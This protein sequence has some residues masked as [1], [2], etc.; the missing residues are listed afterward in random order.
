MN[1]LFF[2]KIMKIE[3][4]FIILSNQFKMNIKLVLLLLIFSTVTVH[5]NLSAQD[6]TLPESEYSHLKTFKQKTNQ[7]SSKVRHF[8]LLLG[9]HRTSFLNPTF[10]QNIGNIYNHKF[11]MNLTTRI[12]YF[13]LIFDVTAFTE[14]IGTSLNGVEGSLSYAFT[15]LPK[16]SYITW[17]PYFGAGYQYSFLNG[18]LNTSSPLI[19]GGMM[20][21]LGEK[22]EFILSGEFK[23]SLPLSNERTFTQ[24]SINMGF[25]GETLKK[26]GKITGVTTCIGASILGILILASLE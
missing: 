3:S 18:S 7:Y 24:Y 23:Q 26:I 2:N 21:N 4:F 12:E 16:N 13:P 10:D 20:V 1:L 25:R 8:S 15:F 22:K 17:V 19:K 14:D 9:Y 6:K 11:G 5:I